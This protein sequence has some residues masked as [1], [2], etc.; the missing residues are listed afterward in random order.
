MAIRYAFT[1]GDQVELPGPRS[2][3]VLGLAAPLEELA[4][5]VWTRDVWGWAALLGLCLPALG[6][7]VVTARGQ[8]EPGAAR[9]SVPGRTFEC[10]R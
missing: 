10:S 1:A 3:A 4:R 5:T 9:L 6:A 2:D 7:A 8:G